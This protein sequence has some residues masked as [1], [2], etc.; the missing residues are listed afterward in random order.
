M[1]G[2]VTRPYDCEAKLEGF[3]D[4]AWNNDRFR[5]S[6]FDYVTT[7]CG[8]NFFQIFCM[9]VGV[10]A[11]ML[12]FPPAVHVMA[13]RRRHEG[14]TRRDFLRWVWE[15]IKGHHEEGG[16]SIDGMVLVRFCRLGL[17]CSLF[18]TVIGFALVP[19]YATGHN[20]ANGFLQY[21]ISNL[22][23][24]MEAD[25]PRFFSTVL[26]AYLI[27]GF[28]L[29]LLCLEWKHFIGMQRDHLK[30]RAQGK[31]GPAAAQAQYSVLVEKVP[32]HAQESEEH[33]RRSFEQLF[34]QLGEIH[35]CV[36]QKDTTRM[37][38][39]KAVE[40]ALE[41]VC[42]CCCTGS[43]LH[44]G[45]KS[46]LDGIVS[47]ERSTAL[48]FRAL[49]SEEGCSTS[50]AFITF[51]EAKLQA[52]AHQVVLFNVRKQKDTE[53]T[54][55]RLYPAP[56]ARDMLWYNA[57][58]PK[59]FLEKRKKMGLAMCYC[60]LVCWSAPIIFIQTITNLE[61]YDTHIP[62]LIG[63]IRG[64]GL[65]NFLTGYLPVMVLLVLLQM[66]PHVLMTIAIRVEGLK[67]KSSVHREVLMRNFWFHMAT[68]VVTVLA[69]SVW[70]ALRVVLDHPSCLPQILGL[71]IPDVSRYFTT[72]I[73][74]RWGTSLPM[75]V[76]WPLLRLL[77]PP[78]QIWNKLVMDAEDPQPAYC[79]YAVEA[80]DVAVVLAVGLV[81]SVIA[82]SILPFCA[83][84][85]AL[86]GAAY[87]WMFRNVYDQEFDCRGHFWFE[88]FDCAMAGLELGSLS[89]GGVVSTYTGF[90]DYRPTALWVLAGGIFFLHAR[91][92]WQWRPL[93]HAITFQDAVEVDDDPSEFGSK[94]VIKG[95]DPRLY[96]DPIVKLV[97]ADAGHG[98]SVE[99]QTEESPAATCR[100]IVP[101]T[102]IGR[103]ITDTFCLPTGGVL[104]K[105][106]P[107]PKRRPLMIRWFWPW[108]IPDRRPPV[109]PGF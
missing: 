83:I 91:W 55:W 106:P 71:T 16:I 25:E 37:Y 86:A 67:T 50:T 101:P 95:F 104:R 38:Q 36:L 65:Y 76:T 9:I 30:R 107:T 33:L 77:Y 94:E 6:E 24:E 69:C 43:C 10:S 79:C 13:P 68:L 72:F 103:Q 59:S 93:C 1:P 3:D 88:L 54:D 39:H 56:E 12:V 8:I 20:D 48:I 78:S 35:S 105:A 51:R 102:P 40:G 80:T 29:F 96:V 7:A 11:V 26:A 84:Y 45:F 32:H 18:G 99:T 100:N 63:F 2:N 97:G 21:T 34:G 19:V 47:L 41:Q 57:S 58:M 70:K 31:E 62:W 109:D 92:N 108:C 23:S 81:Y 85:F 98:P 46:G 64:T 60:G 4:T 66:L 90:W 89:L 15:A 22:E 49:L 73:I 27:S 74:A 17:K 87:H 82:P 28:V 61:T 14:G 5:S 44:Y 53:F 42:C 52:I 75:L